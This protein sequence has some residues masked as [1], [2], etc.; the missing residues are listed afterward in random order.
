MSIG[1][2]AAKV[3]DGLTGIAS[4]IAYGVSSGAATLRTASQSV[5]NL[6]S[7]LLNAFNPDYYKSVY[8][9]GPF[10]SQRRGNVLNSTEWL[11][12]YVNTAW[13]DNGVVRF[14]NQKLYRDLMPDIS[15]YTL[16]FMV[17][18]D[19]SGYRKTGNANYSKDGLSFMNETSKLTPLLA[20]NFVPP[21][22]ELGTGALAGSAGTQ[23]YATKLA[24]TDSMSVTYIDNMNLDVYSM[25]S[26][27]IKY[28]FQVLEGTLEPDPTYISSGTIDYAASFY[29]VKFMPNMSSIQYVGKAIGCF[30]RGMPTQDVIGNRTSNELTTVTFT[31]V[32]SDYREA[33][34]NEKDNWLFA[35]LQ[36]AVLSRFQG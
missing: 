3:A 22:I 31:Y 2:K 6:G 11:T 24:I 18:P 33:N 25:H 28:I 12:Q 19:L 4:Q 27:W 1:F 7:A 16:L 14:I 15:G 17:P 23:H 26:T 32:V 34:L 29:F 35:E 13:A 10:G 30:P 8:S 21:T 36:Q 9:G 20:T 5:V